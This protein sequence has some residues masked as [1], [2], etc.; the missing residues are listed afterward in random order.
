MSRIVLIVEDTEY[1]ATLLEVA[2]LSLPDVELR[3][4]STAQEALNLLNNNTAN[5]AAMVTD[6][7]MPRID[8]FDLIATVRSLPRHTRMPILVIS[9]DSDLNTP[10]RL[11]SLG[12]D[13]Y[14][15][16]PYSPAQVR[17][18]LERLLNA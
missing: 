5:I 1:C 10:E 16:K 11:R 7:H 9:G 15:P 4:A 2:L 17:L 18:T 3:V 8:G 12:A 14:L 6:L 13:A